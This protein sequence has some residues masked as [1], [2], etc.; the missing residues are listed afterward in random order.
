MLKLSQ[1]IQQSWLEGGVCGYSSERGLP[2]DH[3]IKV[4]SQFAD[5]FQKRRFLNI[6]P[7]G[8]YVKTKSAD[9]AVLVSGRDLQI[10]F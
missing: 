9:S 4:W 3:S 10:Q 2:K 6:F 5:Q 1:L 8:S 7:M